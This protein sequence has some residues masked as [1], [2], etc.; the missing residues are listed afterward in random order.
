MTGHKDNDEAADGTWNCF[1]VVA[2]KI[3]IMAGVAN[4]H[5]KGRNLP[6][7]DFVHFFFN[8][9]LKSCVYFWL[10][11][12]IS[13]ILNI[14]IGSGPSYFLAQSCSSLDLITP[15]M[16]TRYFHYWIKI[17]SNALDILLVM[18]LGNMW[19]SKGVVI[20][21]RSVGI[22]TG[23]LKNTQISRDNLLPQ[24]VSYQPSQWGLNPLDFL[25][26]H[27]SYCPNV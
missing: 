15:T 13:N 11:Q 21:R 3:L 2:T 16:P 26:S 20:F 19:K 8:F 14:L 5:F 7:L 22:Q 6:G 23:T 24:M 25:I 27:A 10:P 4:L 12:M 17:G 9:L 18:K 1:A